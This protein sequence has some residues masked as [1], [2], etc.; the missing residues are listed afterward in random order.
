[1]F[2]FVA[3]LF[4]SEMILVNN[5]KDRNVDVSISVPICVVNMYK[6]RLLTKST[7]ESSTLNINT[8]STL[9]LI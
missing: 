4:E 8:S 5:V 7:D 9:S 3:F 2:V 6:I 1:M